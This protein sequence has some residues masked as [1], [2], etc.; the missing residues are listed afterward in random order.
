[1]CGGMLYIAH[2]RIVKS[3]CNSFNLPVVLY[4]PDLT[5]RLS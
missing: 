4:L 1:M 5:R 2:S 3:S